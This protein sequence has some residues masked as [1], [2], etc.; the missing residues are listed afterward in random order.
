MVLPVHPWKLFQVYL[1]G[2]FWDSYFY[3]ND[4][5]TE[6]SSTVRLYADDVIIYR[7]IITTEDVLQL[8]LDLEILSLWVKDWLMS[9]NLSKCKH[10]IITNKHSP[11]IY[12][13]HI[14]GHTIN[15]VNSCKYLGV[16]IT[17]NL[18]WSKHITNIVSKA[19]PVHG[20]LQRNL[21]QCSSSVKAEAYFA[22]VRPTLEYAS[23]IWSPHTTC[24]IN[25]LRSS[26]K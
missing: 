8:Q 21:K 6:I 1:R 26:S 5:P 18:S 17:N 20:F 9:F 2:Q 19:H 4:L 3:I 14:E 23:I 25:H 10:L 24:D 13:Y 7:P 12:D 22:F 16:I 15:K 11:I